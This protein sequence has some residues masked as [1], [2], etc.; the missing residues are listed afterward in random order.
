MGRDGRAEVVADDGGDAAMAERGDQV[1]GVLNQ[2]EKP[3]RSQ[4][5]VV[6]PVPAG[7]SAIAALVGRDDVQTRRS[8]GRHHVA[9]GISQ[10]GKTVQQQNERPPF[11][12]EPS[13]QHVHPQAVDAVD[14]AGPHALGQIGIQ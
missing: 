5:P 1:Q 9:P 4:V 10:F 13:L 2:V 6:V 12:L 3:E 14:K 8:Q 11:G 7:R